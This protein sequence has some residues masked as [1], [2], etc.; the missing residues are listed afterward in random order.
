MWLVHTSSTS[1]QSFL[2]VSN[3]YGNLRSLQLSIWSHAHDVKVEST[4]G[5]DTNTE[6]QRDNVIAVTH[7]EAQEQSIIGR[8]A[9]I[10]TILAVNA[11][12]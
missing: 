6:N 9:E 5:H 4:R 8:S 10:Q 12:S 3:A 11:C 2:L 7:D 1:N